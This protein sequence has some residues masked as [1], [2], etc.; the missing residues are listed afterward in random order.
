MCHRCDLV[1]DLIWSG[2]VEVVLLASGYLSPVDR[3]HFSYKLNLSFFTESSSVELLGKICTLV[4]A[5]EDEYFISC[6]RLEGAPVVCGV[7]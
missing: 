7:L 4:A 1:C 3:A 2:F 6:T 5:R